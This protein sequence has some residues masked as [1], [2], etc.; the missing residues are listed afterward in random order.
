VLGNLLHNACKYTPAGGRISFRAERAGDTVIWRVKDSGIG[1]PPDQVSTI[2]EIFSQLGRSL[3]R[4]QGG[5]GIGLYLVRRLVEMHGGT[6][7][8]HSDG[9]GHGSEFVV[10]LP[11]VV[12]PAAGAAHEPAT[13]SPAEGGTRPRRFLIVDD[14]VDSAVS[15]EILLQR[16][17][18]DTQIAHDGLEAVEAA[19]KFRPDVVLLDI[20]LPRLNGYDACRRIREQPWGRSMVLV[21][22]TGW[23][24]DEDRQTSEAAGF[25]HHI[26][27]PVDYRALLELLGSPPP[28]P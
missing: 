27:K 10:R 3:E 8:A 11:V 9:P 2:F 7:E 6:A 15:L 24:R 17:G 21:A 18:H 5:L 14:N 28:T 25:D 20:G 16:V 12:E 1:M 13:L 4:Q 23:G 22:V 26:V 19:G